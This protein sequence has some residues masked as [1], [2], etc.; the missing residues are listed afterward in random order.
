[1]NKMEKYENSPKQ[2]LN[3]GAIHFKFYNMKKQK[4]SSTQC[5]KNQFTA[6]ITTFNRILIDHSD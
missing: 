6:I 2:Y 4:P 5:C 1:M 3:H